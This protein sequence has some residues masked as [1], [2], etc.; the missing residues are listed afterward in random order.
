MCA[1]ILRASP[2]LTT[3]PTQLPTWRTALRAFRNYLPGDMVKL[4]VSAGVQAPGGSVRSMTVLSAD[5]AGFTGLSERLGGGIVPLLGV[6]FDAMS[7]EI[8][9]QPGTIDK[10]I[11]LGRTGRESRSC[12]GSVP[13]G[14]PLLCHEPA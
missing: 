8:Q 13:C 7:R 9:T 12:A 1:V 5:L 2:K 6:N 4:L 3:F 10:F 14:P 11:V